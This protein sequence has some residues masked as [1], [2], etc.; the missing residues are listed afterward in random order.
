MSCRAVNFAL[1]NE[2]NSN[3]LSAVGDDAEVLSIIKEEIEEKWEEDWLV[4]FDKSWDAMHRCLTDGELGHD[5]GEYPLNYCVLGGK[6][7]YD[8]DDYIVV[9]KSTH[10]IQA[11]NGALQTIT[12]DWMMSRYESIKGYH[13]NWGPDDFD[14]TWQYFEDVREFYSRIAGTDRFVIFTVDL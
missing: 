11:I 9:Y 4:E 6:P 12:R 14:Y 3:I 2:Q 1:D 7:L 10:D 5:N 13:P 8:A